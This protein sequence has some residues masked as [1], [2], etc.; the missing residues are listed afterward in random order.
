MPAVNGVKKSAVSKAQKG[1]VGILVPVLTAIISIL[2][3][4]LAVALFWK[5]SY[6]DTYKAQILA[7]NQPS[8]YTLY[9][10]SRDISSGEYID[11]AIEQFLAPDGL[12]TSDLI[13]VNSDISRLR[14]SG[15]IAAN[16]IITE[17]NTYDPKLENPVLEHTRIYSVD[18]LDTDGAVEGDFI[19]IRIKLYNSGDA[20]S[21]SDYVVASKLQILS[22]NGSTVELALSEGDMLNLNSA[23]IQAAGSKGESRGEIYTGKYVDPANQEKAAITYEGKG[24]QY[25]QQELMEAQN[26]L[27]NKN[28]PEA[29]GEGT[30]GVDNTEGTETTP[31]DD[32]VDNNE[33]SN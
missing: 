15:N 24:I 19:D 5:Y 10:A 22:K 12:A 13:P 16:T 2:L 1:K 33:E 30:E 31:I 28:N 9:K 6:A 32:A 29:E 25:T 27:K 18:Y 14:A 3:T 21:Y 7:G 26:K 11:G 23:V 17:R 8:G 20:T 4:V